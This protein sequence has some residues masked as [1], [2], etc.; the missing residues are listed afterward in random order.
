MLLFSA[1]IVG[2][3]CDIMTN[4]LT[5]TGVVRAVHDEWLEVEAPKETLFINARHIVSICTEKPEEQERSK[6]G[7]FG[8]KKNEEEM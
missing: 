4:D 7:L 5:Y 1:K 8:R 6:K 3:Q 2:K